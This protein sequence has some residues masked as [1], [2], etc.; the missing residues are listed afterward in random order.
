MKKKRLLKL[1]DEEI[2][3]PI[4]NALYATKHFLPSQATDL[5]N[6]I[7][8]YIKEAGFKIVRDKT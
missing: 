4:E 1:T 7:I 8:Q 3:E 6:G 5:A 2:R